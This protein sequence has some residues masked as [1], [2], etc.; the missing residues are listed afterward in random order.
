[1]T[2]SEIDLLL[3]GLTVLIVIRY[4]LILMRELHQMPEKPFGCKFD[5]CSK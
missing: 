2:S 1:M 5:S 4:L 3:G